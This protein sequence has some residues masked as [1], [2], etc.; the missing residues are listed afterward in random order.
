MIRL[1]K[2]GDLRK[3]VK[4]AHNE[5][6]Q[7]IGQTGHTTIYVDC[8]VVP[9]KFGYTRSANILCEIERGKYYVPQY[10]LFNEVKALCDEQLVIRDTYAPKMFEIH[11]D[12]L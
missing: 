10:K 11:W 2:I 6:N 9:V 12:D 5:L 7:Y 4:K 3:A 1:Y 8:T